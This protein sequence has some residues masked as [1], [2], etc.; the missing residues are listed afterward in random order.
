MRC[1]SALP[2]GSE[3]CGLRFRA[4]SLP[5]RRATGTQKPSTLDHCAKRRNSK[6][7]CCRGF[8]FCPK[9]WEILLSHAQSLAIAVCRLRQE[10]TARHVR[11]ITLH[12]FTRGLILSK[13]QAKLEGG[14]LHWDCRAPHLQTRPSG[15]QPWEP[16][17][18][19]RDRGNRNLVK[20]MPD[21]RAWQGKDSATV[22]NISNEG[23][24]TRRKGPLRWRRSCAEPQHR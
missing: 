21:Y 3:T 19:A 11:S 22:I 1:E 18:P 8:T 17:A 13:T 15:R 9:L 14:R 10:A 6:L 12:I 16:R 23:A 5:T 24:K 20:I 2:A 4:A 7:F